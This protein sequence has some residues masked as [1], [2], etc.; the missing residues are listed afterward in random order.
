MINV[1]YEH[2]K[3][4]APNFKLPG[5]QISAALGL[6]QR[7]SEFSGYFSCILYKNL[8]ATASISTLWHCFTAIWR[9]GEIRRVPIYKL[10]SRRW[11]TLSLWFWIGVILCQIR[12][13]AL[14]N[15]LHPVC[16]VFT[17]LCKRNIPCWSDLQWVMRR[18]Q[19]SPNDTRGSLSSSHSVC[20]WFLI[21]ETTLRLE[22][23]HCGVNYMVRLPLS[24]K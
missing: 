6:W 12:M 19:H 2:C 16:H 4:K 22:S 14:L 20:S 17:L 13:C 15:T 8:K 5:L 9:W 10:N 1:V 21:T 11:F 18:K 7:S 3:L 24:S 23:R